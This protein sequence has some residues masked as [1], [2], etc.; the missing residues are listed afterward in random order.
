[1]SR[2]CATSKTATSA[3]WSP[4]CK[5]Y[6]IH[7]CRTNP[8]NCKKNGIPNWGSPSQCGD[9]TCSHVTSLSVAHGSLHSDAAGSSVRGAP[10]ILLAGLGAAKSGL[11]NSC[12]F[13]LLIGRLCE[14]CI[15]PFDGSV[16]GS[17]AGCGL[18]LLASARVARLGLG[19]A[20]RC[21]SGRVR[22]AVVS[23]GPIQPAGILVAPITRIEPSHAGRRGICFHLAAASGRSRMPS[24]ITLAGEVLTLKQAGR[25]T[26]THYQSTAHEARQQ[27]YY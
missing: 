12:G 22:I 13:H 17:A 20:M 1:M 14:T 16:S 5:S 3:C 24:D 26:S 7:T 11:D 9:H 25:N 18:V 19:L 23:W 2:E 27:D 21:L 8:C 6:V 10:P 4:A 15:F